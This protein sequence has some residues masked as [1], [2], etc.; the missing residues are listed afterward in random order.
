MM[1]WGDVQRKVQEELDRV[2]GDENPCREHRSQTPYTEATLLEVQR[3]AQNF[4]FPWR[5]IFFLCLYFLRYACTVPWVPR[6]TRQDVSVGPYTIPK[7]T[8]VV[9]L[10]RAVTHDPKLFP[11]PNQFR[12]ERFLSEDGSKFINDER[13]ATFGLGKSRNVHADP[14]SSTLEIL[15]YCSR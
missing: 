5:A 14:N 12:P 8:Y 11:S 13:V 10:S 3:L 4:F 7:D 9:Y 6:A 2:I 1:K 15:A